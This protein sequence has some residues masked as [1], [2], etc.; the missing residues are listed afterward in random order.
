MTILS[1]E[2]GPAP[3]QAFEKRGSGL[4]TFIQEITPNKLNRGATEPS[5]ALDWYRP[6]P[7]RQSPPCPEEDRWGAA[8]QL[9]ITEQEA[10]L[11]ELTEL[12]PAC[13]IQR[14]WSVLD[15]LPGGP[16]PLTPDP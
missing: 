4:G 13:S 10:T 12:C 11:T 15:K 5:P 2:G 8:K 9:G 1:P 16:Q 3:L 7:K 6:W 14:L